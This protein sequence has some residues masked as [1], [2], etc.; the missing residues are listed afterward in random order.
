[1]AERP[2]LEVVTR[3]FQRPL[4]LKRNQASLWAQTCSDFKQTL[5][6]DN[7]GLGIVWAAENLGKYAPHLVGEYV[8]LLDDDDECIRPTLVAELKEIALLGRPEVIMLK[9]D[10]GPLGV[11]PPAEDW[12]RT[13]GLGRVGCS[14]YVVRREV[15]QAHAGAWFPGEY[16]SDYRFIAAVF[17]SGPRVYWHDVVASRVQRISRGKPE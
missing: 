14:A 7:L 1:M 8:W 13:V 15:W 9:M 5:L 10:H 4:M 11:L 2:F 12:G 16:A 3:C 17:E 6:M